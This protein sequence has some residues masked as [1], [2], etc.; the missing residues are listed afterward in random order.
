MR[1]FAVAN[2]S[3]D[4]CIINPVGAGQG[5]FEADSLGER[6][7]DSDSAGGV[8][9]GARELEGRSYTTSVL[10]ITVCFAMANDLAAGYA[11]CRSVEAAYRTWRCDNFTNTQVIMASSIIEARI[12]V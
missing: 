12:R 10:V 1:F 2:D 6:S 3:A 5:A 9:C 11:T 7:H 4:L 8:S